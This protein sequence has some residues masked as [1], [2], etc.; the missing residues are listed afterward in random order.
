MN[1]F[2][3]TELFD[4]GIKKY[5]D[6]NLPDT[7]LRLWQHFFVKREADNYYNTLLK[8]SPWQQRSRKMYDKVIADPRLTAYYGGENGNAW[9]PLLLEIKK[10]MEQI[11]EINFDRVLLN[12]YRDGKDSVAWHS[13]TLPADGKHHHIASVTFGDTRIFKV[14]HKFN[15]EIRQLDIPLTHG[16]LLL[17]GEAM[18]EYY[19]HHVP[20]TTRAIGPRIN[21]TFRISESSKPVYHATSH[22]CLSGLSK[23]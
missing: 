23:F 16:S 5:T 8:E 9:T 14:R 20:K 4:G 11:T 6:F 13:D 7:E 12:L 17:M 3:E 1:L 21:L 19:E 10:I 2:A 22:N 15:K 18:Q